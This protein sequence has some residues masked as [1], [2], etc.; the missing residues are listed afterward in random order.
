MPQVVAAAF[1][2]SQ[3]S[4]EVATLVKLTRVLMLGPVVLVAGLLY[5]G[6]AA[7]RRPTSYLPWFVLAFL[8]LAA[9]R[10]A[11][12]VPDALADPTRE[13]SRL[14]KIVA[15]AGLG[16]GVELAAVRRVG[17]R[18]AVAVVATLGF[19]ATFSLAAMRV[20]GLTG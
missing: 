17:P 9:L 8:A 14:L 18:V 2:V 13:V 6:G 4:G 16:F 7:D 12:V 19:I 10:S 1:P 15:M 11:G 3:L 20:A 5:R